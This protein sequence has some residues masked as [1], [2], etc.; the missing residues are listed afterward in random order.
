MGSVRREFELRVRSKLRGARAEWAEL[1][2]RRSGSPLK[3]TELRF[4]AM[5]L[6]TDAKASLEIDKLLGRLILE[7]EKAR[8]T[9]PRDK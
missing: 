9:L 2:S 1:R 5:L 8:R 6:R 4:R 7:L 3:R